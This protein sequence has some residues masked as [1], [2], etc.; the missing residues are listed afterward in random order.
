VIQETP[1]LA[2]ALVSYGDSADA[3]TEAQSAAGI[4]PSGMIAFVTLEHLS[5]PDRALEHLDRVLERLG[6][7]RKVYFESDI[8]I[9]PESLAAVDAGAAPRDD[10]GQSRIF[11]IRTPPSGARRIFRDT[12]I[13][14]PERWAV[15]QRRKVPYTGRHA[16]ASA[17]SIVV[18]KDGI[19]LE[20]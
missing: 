17:D 3:I 13:V 14:P 5:A 8:G 11:L 15:A 16:K 1:P 7:S 20:K 6:C 2:G 19:R 4:T 9:E 10:N 18:G 12:P